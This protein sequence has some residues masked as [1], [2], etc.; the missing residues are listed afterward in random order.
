VY[1]AYPRL[2]LGNISEELAAA[3]GLDVKRGNLLYLLLIAV[4]V[5]IGVRMVGGLLTAAL[6]AI[7]PAAARNVS[8]DLTQYTLGATAVGVVSAAVGIVLFQLTGFPAGPLVILTSAVIF[9]CTLPFA[10]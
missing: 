5:A 7:P 3:E 6:V 1:R 8:N 9:V 4:V 10:R 2:V